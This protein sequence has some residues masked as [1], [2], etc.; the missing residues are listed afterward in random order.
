MGADRE[1]VG[2]LAGDAVHAGHFFGGFRHGVRHLAVPRQAALLE[3][4]VNKA[5]ADGGIE[6]L[7]WLGKRRRG[8]FLDPRC[9]AHGLHSAGD[10]NVCGTGLDHLAGLDDGAQ[11]GSAEPVD[12]DAGDVEGKSGQQ[13]GHPGNVPVFFTRTVRV[14]QDDFLDPVRIKACAGHGLADHQGSQIIRTDRRE[15]AAVPAH[16]S[17]DAA[18]KE[19]LDHKNILTPGS[20]AGR[21]INYRPFVL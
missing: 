17:A 19:S 21:G 9:P 7:T 3:Q 6:N 18:N 2:I 14:A 1:G 20:G 4:G 10:H 8:F 12:G 15:R 5:P 13:G 16:R 11:P